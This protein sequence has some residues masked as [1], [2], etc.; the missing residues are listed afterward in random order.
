LQYVKRVDV[1]IMKI[2][3]IKTITFHYAHNYGAVLQAYALQNTL[4]SLGHENK[5]IDYKQKKMHVFVKYGW[6]SNNNII[7]ATIINILV[8]VRYREHKMR[9]YKFEDFINNYLILTKHYKSYEELKL[10]PPDADVYLVGS[11]QV[12]NIYQEKIRSEV[13][14]LKF[15]DENIKRMS[16]AAS[17]GTCDLS[18]EQKKL[19][20]NLITNMDKISVR[21]KEAC[22]FIMNNYGIKSEVHL[23]PVFLL[24][25][26]QWAGLAIEPS[27]RN[28][29]ILCYPL[30]FTPLLNETIK[31]IKGLTGYEVIVLT[32]N[33]REKVIGDIYI[34]NA[35]PRELLGLIKDAQ[36]VLTSSF[37]GL[38]F[39]IIFEKNFYVF[40]LVFQSRINNILD[41]LE[42][43]EQ[44][45]STLENVNLKSINYEKTNT[46]LSGEISKSIDYL[47]R[48]KEE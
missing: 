46:I 41:L 30:S 34:R 8:L 13:S 2:M 26:D 35:G 33:I 14:F 31:K 9:F 47:Q 45:V 28:K 25:K 37:H 15:G 27:F 44:Q 36:I 6:K 18:V 39:S 29:Y 5:I 19:F 16:Y 11:D 23:D 20:G 24:K 21:E 48:L 1:F 22:D 12:W 7:T 42:L 40:P 10:N 17:M 43:S 32:A 4:L 38:A 3:K